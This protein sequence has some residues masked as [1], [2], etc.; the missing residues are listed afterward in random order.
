[1]RPL[2]DET[3]TEPRQR[4]FTPLQLARAGGVGLLVLTLVGGA[5]AIGATGG[6]RTDVDDPGAYIATFYDTGDVAGLVAAIPGAAF[7]DASVEDREA[8]VQQVL[9]PGVG[10]AEVSEPETVA[11]V[12]VTPVTTEDGITWCVGA[13]GSVTPSCLT[14]FAS[15]AT[16]PSEGLTIPLV[17]VQV[18][19]GSPQALR[20]IVENLGDAPIPI[21]ALTL[22]ATDDGPVEADLV[23]AFVAFP[24]QQPTPADPSDATVPPGG[25]LLLVWVSDEDL[26]GRALRFGE[27]TEGVDLQ[28]ATMTWLHR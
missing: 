22:S 24:G 15:V 4:R 26:T 5:T 7:G 23:E 20:L 18:Q 9:R 10:V 16:T 2:S 8:Q 14:G 19:L 11:G 21:G 13:G 1:M 17:D 3:T 28:V 6:G 12:Q 25:A 27:G